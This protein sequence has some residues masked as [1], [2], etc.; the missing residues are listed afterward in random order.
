MNLQLYMCFKSILIQ[1]LASSFIAKQTHAGFFLWSYPRMC[2]QEV[3]VFHCNLC[4]GLLVRVIRTEWEKNWPPSSAPVLNT[5]A[6]WTLENLAKV[7]SFI[8]AW[9]LLLDSADKKYISPPECLIQEKSKTVENRCLIIRGLVKYRQRRLNAKWLI[10]PFLLLTQKNTFHKFLKSH[11]KLFKQ[12]PLHFATH[13]T[14][15]SFSGGVVLSLP[16]IE[17]H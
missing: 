14:V 4:R 12:W 5:S 17:E 16:I 8:V 11:H 6:N 10:P 9:I 2:M 7:Y 15:C 3:Y 1:L 13:G